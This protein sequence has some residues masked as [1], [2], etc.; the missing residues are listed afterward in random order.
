[1]YKSEDFKKCLFDP[2]KS[3]IFKS[4]EQLSVIKSVSG[5]INDKL[6]KYII[7]V[8]DYNS[9]IVYKNRDLKTRKQQ[10]AEFAGY[11]LMNDG[12]ING[13]IN[14][15]YDY[16]VDAIDLFLKRFIH[17]RIWY[18][19][20]CNESIFWEYGK[21]MMSP[22]SAKDD[23]GKSMTEKAVT[24]AMVLKTKLSEDMQSIDERLDSSYKRL[25]GDENS[26]KFL[27]RATTPEIVAKERHNK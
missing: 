15:E 16:V 23:A 4:Y 3:D 13:I 11:D 1:M 27:N 25:Y 19:I 17:N 12:A 18:M 26:N 8:Y 2:F 14:L 7:V 21:R 9:P 10:G 20:S 24:E 22:V 5:E 6:M